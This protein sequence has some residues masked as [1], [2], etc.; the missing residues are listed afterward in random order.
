VNVSLVAVRISTAATTSAPGR[1]PDPSTVAPGTRSNVF[2]HRGSV[3]V[4]S[5]WRTPVA[6]TVRNSWMKNRV[7]GRRALA[8]LTWTSRWC[9]SA[10]TRSSGNRPTPPICAE[11]SSWTYDSAAVMLS[12]SFTTRSSW[13]V[14]A[15]RTVIS[16]P[17]RVR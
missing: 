10:S 7:S 6:W 17:L 12:N 8:S 9:S 1:A 2:T 11:P 4:S 5:P 16:S 14:G 13:P 15:C 3:R